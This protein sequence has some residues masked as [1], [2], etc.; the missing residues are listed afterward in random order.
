SFLLLVPTTRRPPPSPLF[1]YTT[2]F[3]SLPQPREKSG[4]DNPKRQ[5]T[6]K[7]PAVP[8]LAQVK[9]KPD[10]SAPTRQGRTTPRETRAESLHRAPRRVPQFRLAGVQPR[11]GAEIRRALL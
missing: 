8:W 4:Q 5:R 11:R 2:L 3:R 9:R 1:P 10:S 7:P 6:R